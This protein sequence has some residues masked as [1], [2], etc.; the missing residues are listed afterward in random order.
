MNKQPPPATTCLS[1]PGGPNQLSEKKFGGV[2]ALIPKKDKVPGITG[3]R[4][5]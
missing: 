3:A 5:D 4:G 2:P 1:S